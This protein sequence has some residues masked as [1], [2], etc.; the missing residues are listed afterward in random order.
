MGSKI[1]KCER[2]GESLV[3]KRIKWLELSETDGNYYVIIPEGH[4]SQGYFAFGTKCATQEIR[5]TIK[6][7]KAGN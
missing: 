4:K 6:Q 3:W 2:C 5:E 7:I 1:T